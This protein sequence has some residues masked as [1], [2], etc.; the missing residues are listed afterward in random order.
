[1]C[2]VLILDDDA[3]GA[4][5][6]KMTL[7]LNSNAKAD[8][9][10]NLKD[11]IALVTTA[12]DSGKPYEIFLIDLILG[13]GKDG[14]EAMK[15]L[16]RASPDSDA[17][18]FTGFGDM[19]SGLRA[20]HA[21]AFRYLSK[22]FDNQEL[23]YLVEALK[24][25]RKIQREH[26][27]QKIFGGMMEAALKQKSF[28]AVAKV[29]VNHSL[30]LGFERAH[31]FW[32]PTR[33]EVNT[34]NL[35]GEA[36]AGKDSIPNFSGS[37]FP[38]WYGMERV[39]KSRNAIFINKD[40]LNERGQ[41][42]KGSGSK[43]FSPQGET[44]VLPLWRGEILIGILLLDY[45]RS[46]KILSE[47]ER[48][49]LNLFARQVSVVMDHASIYASEK[50]ALK[51]ADIIRNI[52]HD[53]TTQA[54]VAS[55]PKLLEEVRNQIGQLMDVSN[56]AVAL[57]DEEINELT[58]C[59]LCEQGKPKEGVRRP[60]SQG[61]ESF[62]L[63]QQGGLFLKNGDVKEFV[64]KNHIR[65]QGRMPAGWLG[66]PLRVG[67]ATIGV[68]TLQRFAGDKDFSE[69]D[70]QLLVS[71]ADQLA[72]AIHIS[73]LAE[74]EREDA[75][76]MQNLQRASV[77]ML[78]LA[79][80]NESHLWD[81][82][83][84]LATANFGLG[85]N[86]AL[87]LTTNDN[88]RFLY[89]ETGIG[90]DSRSD[91]ERDWKRD[92]KRHYDFD[93]YLSDL[94]ANKIIP[95][96]FARRASKIKI[97][98]DGCPEVMRQVIKNGAREIISE[99]D[100]HTKL[101][102]DINRHFS[103][104][105]CA[106]LPVRAG[107]NTLGLLIVDNKHNRKNLDEKSLDR[108]QTLL[109]S[110]GLVRE[111]LTQSRNSVSVLE[112]N[113][114]I[115]GEA[116][117]QSLKDTLDH[118]CKTA[119]AIS[120][121]DWAVIFPILPG[122]T[123]RYKLD[124]NTIG[125]DGALKS[126]VRS[127]K[128]NPRIG[129]ITQHVLEKGELIVS[130][131]DGGGSMISRL[132][133]TNSHFI[134]SEGVK[135][136]I[137]VLVRDPYSEEP[138]GILYL[139]YRRPRE[140]SELEVRHAKSFASLAAV[141]ISKV[142]HLDEIGQ[143]KRLRV[144]LITTEIMGKE[145][146]LDEILAKVLQKMQG[147]F[148]HTELCV[149]LYDGDDH[150]L[151]FAPATL[152][153]YHIKNPEFKNRQIFP[154]GQPER[155]SIACKVAEKTLRTRKVEHI[156]IPDVLSD[157]DYL[158]LNPKTRSELCISLMGSTGDLLG[159]LA[160]ERSASVFGKDDIDLIKTVARQLGLAIE[161][162]QHTE[163]LRFLSTVSAMTA[164]SSDIAH[165]MNNEV[166]KIR[167]LTYLIR[168]FSSEN[169]KICDYAAQIDESARL[170]SS[171]G[172]WSVQTGHRIPL[173]DSIKQCIKR[174]ANQR[175]I[176]VIPQFE[177]SGVYIHANPME[178]QRILKHLVRNADKAMSRLPEKKIKLSTHPLRDG[179]VE[180]LFGDYGSGVDETVRADIFR[181]ATSTKESGGYGLLLI[182]QLIEAMGGT[183]KLLPSDETDL[184]AVFSI[185][186][187]TANMPTPTE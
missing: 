55:L 107:K 94:Q 139:D 108:L 44:A 45:G 157:R 171:V 95:T 178:L 184:G 165:D 182:R 116:G 11:A 186:I 59:L 17:I 83:L 106:V 151:K 152:K 145:L 110:A 28:H 33:E 179:R 39:R 70:R 78:W 111:T 32:V 12:S 158:P 4:E 127:I 121:S 6:V 117:N 14:I 63:K 41:G 35:F 62:L 5:E 84:T 113:Y 3:Y 122:G 18:I 48:T 31:L 172:P 142:R 61:L 135:A 141:A 98:L 149:L 50:W 168:E 1:M 181:R 67:G 20:Y 69:R 159:V 51:E 91:S 49:L 9:C 87:L 77:D 21:G 109:D 36:C 65:V 79:R 104:S 132:N 138:L 112:A 34:G 187:P 153:F 120:E 52:V 92:E 89:G 57:L 128:S 58:F 24:E 97:E 137:G 118:I 105:T 148:K 150:A 163:R 125:H 38:D 134:R 174:L 176:Q 82:V 26:S 131:I 64:E 161:R 169:P 81:V 13:P 167:G 124:L 74:V 166:G 130:D 126:P 154:L 53:V 7:E 164:W 68:L 133:L 75:R 23:L 29:V 177:A 103:F 173:D 2:R 88:Q 129:G 183:I 96:P 80:E 73:H 47:H 30:K 123:E 60:A 102:R 71:V 90:S 42:S 99:S 147:L 155:G 72:A 56:F 160:L 175:G 115:M 86:R 43:N 114:D 16:R 156:N 180:I 143:R 101:P 162:A 93:A 85:F 140:F 40:G 170:L 19:E 15:I 119:R 144:T 22:P 25:W 136:L 54:A 27:W 8:V 66:V 46:D 37:L 100:V 10:V 76:R 185:R 146:G